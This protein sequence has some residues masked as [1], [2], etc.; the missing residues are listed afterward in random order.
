MQ[1][2]IEVRVSCSRRESMMKMLLMPKFIRARILQTLTKI[3]GMP[4]RCRL[5]IK[6]SLQWP[7]NSRP[8]TSINSPAFKRTFQLAPRL[9]LKKSMSKLNRPAKLKRLL[10]LRHCLQRISRSEISL[11]STTKCNKPTFKPSIK[12]SLTSRPRPSWLSRF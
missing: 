5:K 3:P 8:L 9:L 10:E 12:C 1:P 2:R 11:G 7:R 6:H 4:S